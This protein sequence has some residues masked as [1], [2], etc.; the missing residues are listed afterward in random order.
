[1]DAPDSLAH[2]KHD[3]RECQ[4]AHNASDAAYKLAHSNWQRAS[5]ALTAARDDKVVPK[6]QLDRATNQLR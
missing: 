1:M 4:L 2:L 6:A 5:A 3:V